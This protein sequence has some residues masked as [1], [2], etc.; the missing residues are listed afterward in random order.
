[1]ADEVTE[2]Q[3]G[4]KLTALRPQKTPEERRESLP[5]LITHPGLDL[6]PRAID[7]S[8][9]GPYERDSDIM[10]ATTTLMLV[11]VG[12]WLLDGEALARLLSEGSFR[13]VTLRH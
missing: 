7:V 1:M 4:A 12:F 10:L 13:I 6:N 5:K 8:V 9:K 2:I 3:G 11:A